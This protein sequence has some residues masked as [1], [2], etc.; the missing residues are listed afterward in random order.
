ML[1]QLRLE[2]YLFIVEHASIKRL[3]SQ[4]GQ[5]YCS[6]KTSQQKTTKT[7]GSIQREA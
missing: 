4:A 2:H 7:F 5:R 3:L 6:E 1:Q